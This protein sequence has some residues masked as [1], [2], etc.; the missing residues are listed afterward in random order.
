[1]SPPPDRKLAAILSA[2][3]VGYSLMMGRD[4]AGTLDTLRDRRD[5]MSRLIE[6]Y[7]G[8]I[9]GTA[10]DS[11]LADFPS[12]VNAVECA[13]R[14]Q[15][16]FLER[17]A[18]VEEDRRMLFRIGINLGDVLVEDD[19]LYGEGVNIAARLQALAEPGGILISGTVF[20]QIKSKLSLGFEFLGPQEVKNIAES[21]PA[22]RV[23]LG[24][25]FGAAGNGSLDFA[26]G[27]MASAAGQAGQ[28]SKRQ[29]FIR[30]AALAG[31]LMAIPFV[32]NMLTWHGEPWFIWPALAVLTIFSLRSIWVWGR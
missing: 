12:V 13:V 9:V 31:V 28:L 6:E 18:A 10:G 15:R 21:V 3:V 20:D 5:F 11:V 2:D 17:N 24:E 27:G 7:H 22:Y 16:E 4:E 26:G 8:R 23:L 32:I 19:D 14:I 1:M 29:R 25:E 30:R